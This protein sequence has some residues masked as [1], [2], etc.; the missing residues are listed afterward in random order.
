MA[1]TPNKPNADRAVHAG[2]ILGS[3]ALQAGH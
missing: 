1:V 2:L 3:L